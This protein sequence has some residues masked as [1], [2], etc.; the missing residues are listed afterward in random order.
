MGVLDAALL[1]STIDS[2]LANFSERYEIDASFISDIRATLLEHCNRNMRE[3]TVKTVQVGGKV[4]TKRPKTGYNIFV[5]EKFAEAKDQQD[6]RNSQ[7]KMTEF[8]RLWKDLDKA[9]Q[10]VYNAKAK[11][12]NAGAASVAASGGTGHKRPLTGYNLF[13]KENKNEIKANPTGEG[14]FMT[15][16]GAAWRALSEDEKEDYRRRA[17]EMSVSS[18]E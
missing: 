12:L 16:V 11:E 10:E 1:E 8:S 7:E 5:K 4:T 9:E 17:K 18:A 3:E 13:Y 2:A 6:P 15:Q 14:K